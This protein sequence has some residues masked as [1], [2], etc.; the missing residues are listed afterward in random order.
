MAVR[1]DKVAWLY[2]AEGK[3][4]GA[5]SK[6]KALFY[7]PGGKREAG[8]TDEQTLAREVEEELSVRLRPETISRF[9]VFE[10][11]AD[12]KAAGVKV[13]MS[14]YFADFEGELRPAAE[15]EEYLWLTYAERDR[16]SAVSQLIFD[17][18]HELGLLL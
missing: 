4:L 2:I 6:G 10:A 3:L 12:G 14:C 11:E 15:I 18:L 13:V 7:I 16:V 17:Q 9:G 5:R 8:E 1:I